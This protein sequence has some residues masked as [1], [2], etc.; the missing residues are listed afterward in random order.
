MCPPGPTA[1]TDS[2]AEIVQSIPVG[3]R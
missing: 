3:A 2:F 1:A